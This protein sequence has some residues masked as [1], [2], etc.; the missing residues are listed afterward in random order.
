DDLAH[1]AKLEAFL[2]WLAP[3]RDLRDFF[4]AWNEAAP[5][6]LPRLAVADWRATAR[7]AREKAET[8]PEL[9][10]GLAHLAAGQARI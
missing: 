9:A 1:H 3:P 7:R 5:A 10:A 2:D 8:L 4:L 6:T